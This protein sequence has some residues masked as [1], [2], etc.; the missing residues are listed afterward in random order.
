MQQAISDSEAREALIMD[1]LL[2]LPQ[3]HHFKTEHIKRY[4][5]AVKNDPRALWHVRRLAGI[6]GSEIGA[7]VSALRDEDDPFGTTPNS[8]VCEKL[9]IFPP[10]KTML[11][12]R[13]G[14]VSETCIRQFFLEDYEASRDKKT[15]D[16]MESSD[17]KTPFA[18]MR[19]SPDDV[20]FLGGRRYLVDYKR[21]EIA[22]L[23]ENIYMRYICQLHQGKMILDYNGVQIDGMLLVQFPEKGDDLVVSEISYDDSIVADIVKAGELAWGNVLEGKTDAYDWN[24]DLPHVFD[25]AEQEKLLELSAEFSRTKAMADA[26]VADQKKYQ[27]QMVE[28]ISPKSLEAGTKLSLLGVKVGLSE[29]F[30]ADVAGQAIGDDAI[31]QAKKPVYSAAVMREYLEKNGVD[32]AQFES[33][34]TEWDQPVLL[35][36]MAERGMDQ[37]KFMTTKFR[38]TSSFGEE[39]KESARVAVTAARDE[40]QVVTKESSRK[41]PKSA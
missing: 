10:K 39:Y 30:N 22:S 32:M 9:L 33:G 34:E 17:V 31:L 2:K 3:S 11:A 19:Y 38:M 16:M 35:E 28:M 26:L 37:S 36:M 23:H 21:P 5:N 14:I 8:I 40:F 25:E 41:K 27:E 24:K 20:V 7:L 18:W 1:A 15:I 6:G 29:K 4:L 13:K 12:M